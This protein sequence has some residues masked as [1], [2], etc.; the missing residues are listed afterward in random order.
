MIS[1]IS[2]NFYLWTVNGIQLPWKCGFESRGICNMIQRRDDDFNW[3]KIS[4]ATYTK[5]TGPDRATI[6]AFYITLMQRTHVF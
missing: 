5:K 3:R 1:L 4:G 6:G 2:Y